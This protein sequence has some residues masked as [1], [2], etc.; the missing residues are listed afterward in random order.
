MAAASLRDSFRRG[1]VPAARAPSRSKRA[2]TVPAGP[3]L[4]PTVTSWKSSP[5]HPRAQPPPAA[6]RTRR[7][8]RASYLP[9][10]AVGAFRPPASTGGAAPSLDPPAPPAQAPG[11]KPRSPSGGGGRCRASPRGD[12]VGALGASAAGGPT[13]RCR[14]RG[15]GAP[16]ERRGTAGRAVKR[17]T[18]SGRALGAAQLG[19]PGGGGAGC[20]LAPAGGDRSS[21]PLQGWAA[22]VKSAEPSEALPLSP[23]FSGTTCFPLL[24]PG[25]EL[26]GTPAALTAVLSRGS[27]A[28][29]MECQC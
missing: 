25:G 2:L 3:C 28:G 4:L 1:P 10:E 29:V 15:V 18:R 13:G 12:A 16:C 6:P 21:C 19:P 23:S 20:N 8:G 22:R 11:R 27:G 17:P 7:P 9:P 26:A 24:P 14:G 5:A